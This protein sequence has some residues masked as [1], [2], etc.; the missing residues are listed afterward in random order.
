MHVWVWTKNTVLLAQYIFTTIKII[1]SCWL[2]ILQLIKAIQLEGGWLRCVFFLM[3][4]RLGTFSLYW[5]YVW[6]LFFFLRGKI[7]FFTYF[8]F[9]KFL[10]FF[11]FSTRLVYEFSILDK[12][13]KENCTLD[14]F[15]FELIYVWKYMV[16]LQLNSEIYHIHGAMSSIVH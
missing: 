1:T 2:F 14:L 8:K 4:C 15:I 11:Y 16:S 10:F 3:T 7:L 12:F 6:T 9:T 13:L 5:W